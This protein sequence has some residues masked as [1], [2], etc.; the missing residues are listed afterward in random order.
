MARVART[1]WPETEDA[2]LQT[3]SSQLDDLILRA[4]E[5]KMSVAV[6]HLQRRVRHEEQR[7]AFGARSC[8]L[9]R[10][11]GMVVVCLE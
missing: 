11:S 5:E 1:T 2:L 6:A 4:G 9:V 10:V 3:L 7:V 8:L